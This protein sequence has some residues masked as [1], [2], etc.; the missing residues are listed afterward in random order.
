MLCGSLS[1]AKSSFIPP[2]I[3]V[4]ALKLEDKSVAYKFS[5]LTFCCPPSHAISPE[6]TPLS[7]TR[8]A[9]SVNSQSISHHQSLSNSFAKPF[10]A[11][12]APIHE[13]WYKG[14][15]LSLEAFSVLDALYDKRDGCA[16]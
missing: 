6:Q 10:A 7:H 4:D 2:V 12:R 9:G 13:H 14:T 5:Q 3:E 1:H 15:F 11:A 8:P 16:G